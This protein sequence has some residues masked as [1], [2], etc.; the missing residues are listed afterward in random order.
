MCFCAVIELYT[1]HPNLAQKLLDRFCS[2][3]QKTFILDQNKSSK[4]ILTIKPN[5]ANNLYF[6]TV[7][8]FICQKPPWSLISGC[9]IFIKKTNFSITAAKAQFEPKA[10][11][12]GSRCKLSHSNEHFNIIHAN[13]LR[14]SSKKRRCVEFNLIITLPSPTRSTDVN[15]L[16]QKINVRKYVQVSGTL[17]FL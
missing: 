10:V 11:S 8:L 2:N 4:V 15:K 1:V 17:N 13:Q 6:S 14:L 5:L 12:G 9:L 16:Y 3:S 7:L